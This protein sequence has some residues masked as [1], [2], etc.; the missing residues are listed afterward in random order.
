MINS[1]ISLATQNGHDIMDGPAV[2]NAKSA[3]SGI[4]N[5]EMWLRSALGVGPT[6]SGVSVG[7]GSAM[8]ITAVYACVGLRSECIA[9]LPLF[10]MARDGR[11]R[12]KA[13]E[14]PLFPL[15]HDAPNPWQ[16]SF[17]W[18]EMMEGH[19][20][21]RGNAYSYIIRNSRGTVKS[22]IPLHP[23][24]VQVRRAPDGEPFYGVNEEKIRGVFSRREI[25]HLRGMSSDG[26]TGLSPIGQQRELMGW[27]VATR[28]HGARVFSNGTALS[29]VLEYPSA[30]NEEILKRLREQWQQTYG[31]VRNSGKVA[32]LEGGMKWHQVGMNLEDA[33]FI[34]V[35]AYQDRKIYQIYRCPPHMLGDNDKTTSWGTGIEQM[36]IGF[37]TYTLRP[38]GIRWEQAIHQMLLMPEERGQFYAHFEFEGLLRGDS[39]AR[40]EAL[41]TKRQ[42]GIIN[43]NEWRELEDMDPIE[44]EGGDAYLV[45]SALISMDAAAQGR[46]NGAKSDGQI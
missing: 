33:Q 21:L 28:E 45:N 1:L 30:L 43:A 23:D 46:Q 5:P 37:V 36:S 42:N 20:L 17:E 35:M 18:R 31:G 12:R 27:S 16:T 13:T 10:L 8:G 9:S 14:H 11:N 34:E 29:G 32:I 44:G 4:A 2:F 25:F 7:P 41:S 24:R 39:K 40:A 19:C 22:L 26:Y 15:L 3:T 38:S 6:A